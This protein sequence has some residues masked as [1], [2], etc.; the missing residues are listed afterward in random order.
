M[1]PKSNRKARSGKPAKP[2]PDF[3]LFPHATH[4]WAKRIRQKLHYFGPVTPERG[5]TGPGDVAWPEG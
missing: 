1:E 2:H 3:P 4:R 5:A